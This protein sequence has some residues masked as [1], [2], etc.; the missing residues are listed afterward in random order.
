MLQSYELCVK[1]P[2]DSLK[3]LSKSFCFRGAPPHAFEVENG[4]FRYQYRGILLLRSAIF[5][6][7]TQFLKDGH[8]HLWRIA[9]L[10]FDLH[11]LCM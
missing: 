1:L 6:Y 9:F 8:D 5:R 7:Q 11:E 3:I 4:A 10:G 2:N